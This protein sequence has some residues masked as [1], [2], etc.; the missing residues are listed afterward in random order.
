[1]AI[2]AHL[3][4]VVI[5]APVERVWQA[6]VTAE[7]TTRYF[8]RVHYAEP[9][10]AGAPY[11]QVLPDGSTAVEG[12][13]EATDPPHR[14][15]VTWGIRYDDE[16]AAEAP[17]RVEWTLRPAAPDGSST[18]VTLRHSDLASSP[19]TWEHVRLGW[20][21]V[22][23]GLKTWLETGTELGPLD[24]DEP[25]T[26]AATAAD[27]SATWHRA[28]A[29]EANNSTWELLDRPDRSAAEDDDLL[30]R[31]Y[32]AAYHWARAAGSGPANAARASW[33]ISRAHVVLGHGD[34]A[35]HH[36]RRCEAHCRA[37]DLADFDLA[38]AHEAT[39]RA[40]ACLG[41]LDEARAARAAAAEVPIADPQDRSIVE[42]DLAAGPWF[43]VT[44]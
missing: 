34:L 35:L 44:P 43:G 36:A 28:Q 19:L 15:V 11:R 5:K 2:T 27:V 30:Y 1:M 18:L 21:G 6:L 37:A 16:L 3:Y 10:V 38:D 23:D 7:D 9:L 41:H 17:G 24:L 12:V 13:V 20:H 32:A 26:D 33:L 29:V 22:L 4:R 40:L 39:A 25:G 42:A 14:L 31:A 8:H